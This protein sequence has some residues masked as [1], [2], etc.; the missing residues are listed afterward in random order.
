MQL[1]AVIASYTGQSY[2]RIVETL[3]PEALAGEPQG[4]ATTQGFL[5]LGL[6]CQFVATDVA[7]EED[8]RQLMVTAAESGQIH[9]L[10]NNAAIAKAAS[11]SLFQSSTA[12]FDRVVAVNLRGPYL[13]TKSALPYMA[14][15]GAT[16]NISSTRSLMRNPAVRPMPPAKGALM[17]SPTPW[18]CLW[19]PARSGSTASSPVG[20]KIPRAKSNLPY[21]T[22]NSIL[23]AGWACPRILPRPAYSWPA[24][25]QDLLREQILLWTA[26]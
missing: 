16:I 10:I 15:G 11:G 2:Q 22:I 18:L 1:N 12:D 23:L 14:E 19:L 20:L 21:K 6:N 3:T 7:E 17:P 26:V 4:R 25:R 24:L 5:N 9:V 8:C 13:C